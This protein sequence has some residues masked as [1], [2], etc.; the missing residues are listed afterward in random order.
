MGERRPG[1]RHVPATAR[2]V[3]RR[4]GPGNEPGELRASQAGGQWSTGQAGGPEDDPADHRPQQS[5]RPREAGPGTPS[6]LR[7]RSQQQHRRAAMDHQGRRQPGL[8]HGPAAHI[9]RP[10]TGQRSDPGRLQ[11]RWHPGGLEDREQRG[12]MG[13]PGA[14][15]LRGRDHPQSWW[16]G[17]AGVG[18][19]GAQGRLSCRSP[20]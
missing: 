4:P 5:R 2:A 10:A 15:A 20:G 18:A 3:L 14:R 1:R 12:R 17:P 7:L 8:R 16:Q 9:R 19:M 6:H 13:A 11:R